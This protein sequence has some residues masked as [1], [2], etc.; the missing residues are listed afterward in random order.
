MKKKLRANEVLWP[1]RLMGTTAVVCVKTES[2]LYTFTF[3]DECRVSGGEIGSS[4]IPAVMHG[5]SFL[6][7]TLYEDRVMRDSH[8]EFNELRTAHIDAVIVTAT[9]K[10]LKKA[11]GKWPDEIGSPWSL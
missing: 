10:A 5:I 4:P 11:I 1:S 2:A 9:K 8:L 3:Q 6:S 7:S